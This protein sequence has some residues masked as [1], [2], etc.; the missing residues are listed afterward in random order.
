[1]KHPACIVN[2]NTVIRMCSGFDVDVASQFGLVAIVHEW[3]RVNG[4]TY[5]TLANETKHR[6][7]HVY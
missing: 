2:K 5:V 6:I 3:A 4:S 1:M 7:V